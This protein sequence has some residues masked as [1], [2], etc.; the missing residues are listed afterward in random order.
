MTNIFSK[1][2]MLATGLLALHSN[3]QDSIP[4]TQR[5][6]VAFRSIDRQDLLGGIAVLDYEE[7]QAKDENNYALADITALVSGFN[8]AS[9][10]GNSDFL[11]MVD[12]VPRDAGS[13]LPS[14]I[15][16]ITIL[17]GAQAVVLYGSRGAKGAILITT[18][19]GNRSDLRIKA[20]VNT[21]WHAI[22]ELPGYLNSADYMTLYNEALRND[23]LDP[24][25]SKSDIYNYASGI[26]PYRYP[27]V[28]L[29]SDDYISRTYNRTEANVEFRGG[30]E[31]AQYYASID[32]QNAGDFVKFG[33]NDGRGSQ[34]LAVRGN[35]D[36]RFSDRIK[37]YVNTGVSFG[38][39]KSA[40]GA[41]FWQLTSTLRPNRIAPL[42]PLSYIDPNSMQ[43]RK[44]L[45]T[46]DIYEGCFLAGSLMDQT[47]GVADAYAAGKNTYNYRKFE[48]ATGL[49]F[50]LQSLLRGLSAH[51]MMSIDYNTSYNTSYNN[52]YA[53]Y[54]PEWSDYSGKGMI[55]SLT[56]HGLDKKSGV[57][58][59]G[60]SN[61]NQT[62]NF[63]VHFDY[64]RTFGEGH[65]VYGSLLANGWQ[66]SQSGEYHHKSNVNLGLLG[67]YNYK[68]RYYAELGLSAIHSARLAEGH[69][70]AVNYSATLGWNIA[71][72]KFMEN[73]I[74]SD[75]T[76]SASYSHLNQDLDI[77]GYY[78]YAR[79]IYQD[80]E[81]Q[82]GWGSANAVRATVSKR[83][84]N[85]DLD[86]VK[87]N[88]FSVN[89]HG[90]LLKKSLTFDMSY[91]TSKTSDLL[92][93]PNNQYPSFM[94]TYYPNSSFLPYINYNAD[95]R[96]GF[97]MSVNYRKEFGKLKFGAGANITI[98]GTKASK[99]DDS[100]F[101]DAY[102]YREGQPL[103]ALWGYECLGFFQSDEEVAA[104]P[105]QTSFGSDVKAGDLRYK[106]QNG[107][108][109][110]D[111]KDQVYLAKG[112]WYGT[113]TTLGFNVTLG[114]K[115]FTLFIAATGNF[116]AK[117]FKNSS[118]YWMKGSDKY[119][120]EA[121]GR[122]TPETRDCAT[123]PRLTTGSGANNYQ[124]S[125]FWLYSTDK[126]SVSKIQLTYDFPDKLF[127]NKIVK[128]IAVF[129]SMYD[130]FTISKNRSLLETNIGSAP[131]T[132]FMQFGAKVRL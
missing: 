6:N 89:L 54:Q 91:F 43:A 124:N 99:R 12:G 55:T 95:K 58:N 50:D 84:E 70:E 105:A 86:F 30:G 20:S 68:H 26:N 64:D 113:P 73:S 42:I 41:D 127:E 10:W 33:N 122:W 21:G 120:V 44:M 65:N 80:A 106:D 62:I 129:A 76:L 11:V 102:Q 8:G 117:A 125:D 109:V 98:Y 3:A 19:R 52:S 130:L 47:N 22:K 82:S 60:G 128:G 88:E 123:L 15:A 78:Y 97:D 131:Q 104:A 28:N 103:D 69:R 14:D 48:F 57:Q 13:V 114:Y 126:F 29:L 32:Y 7:L 1:Y 4:Q 101:N 2:I 63:N 94:T 53:T 46:A 79:N 92:I 119:S 121:Q 74:F 66:Q 116:G 110:I 59:M 100:G 81:T 67:N 61:Y 93:I 24:L 31:K 16:Q 23:G 27:D 35:V 83:G 36:M 40:A 56:M 75:L 77:D 39:N 90:E 96:N 51:A 132:R 17:K 45:E 112:G 37:A 111:E 87:R 34:S 118:Y 72:E 115:G 85:L 107:D 9:L 38:S 108:G 25:Y 5:V 49:D 18:K 71:R